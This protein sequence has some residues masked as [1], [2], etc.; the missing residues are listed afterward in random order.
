MP[1]TLWNLM[2]WK[3]PTIWDI[4]T[5]TLLLFWHWEQILITLEQNQITMKKNLRPARECAIYWTGHAI[6][7][8]LKIKILGFH[9]WK[10]SITNGSDFHLSIAFLSPPH[11]NRSIC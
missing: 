11:M 9:Y 8:S 7:Q 4:L 2:C 10:S 5:V 1:V 3:W 6:M